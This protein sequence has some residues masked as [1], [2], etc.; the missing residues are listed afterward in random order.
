MN[1]ALVVAII[2]AVVALV[3]AAFS[4]WTQ[5]QVAKR[6][7]EGKAEERRSDA[8]VVLDRYRGPLLDAAWQLGD[9]VDNIRHKKFLDYL[10]EGTGREQDARLTTLFRLAYYLGWREFVRTQVQLLRFEKE[11]DT[12]LVAWL[13]NDVTW[14][15]ATD[16]LD[17]A[18]AMLW[19]D[20]QRGIGELMTE[21]P[22]GTSSVVRGHAAFH[23]DYSKIFASWM[24][25][26][27]DDLLSPT[28]AVKS[29][30]LRLVQWALYG[31]VRQL[32]EEG[33]YEEGWIDRSAEEIRQPTREEN[34]TRYEK[35]VRMH[36]DMIKSSTASLSVVSIPAPDVLWG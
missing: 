11:E 16:N 18:W 7:R 20:E 5:L 30:R 14:V 25:R 8:K 36:L 35:K 4:G 27:A 6:E 17:E 1:T 22:P 26:F 21:Q 12:R 2:S 13:L 10:S 15:L 3:S 32:D 23:R 33:A 31:L 19:G 24:E 29:D 34:I 28:V 9:R